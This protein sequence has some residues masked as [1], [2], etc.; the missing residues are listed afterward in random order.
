MSCGFD[1]VVLD[2][3]VLQKELEGLGKNQSH[4]ES[5]TGNLSFHASCDQNESSNAE[6]QNFPQII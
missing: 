2:G 1:S 5:L 6:R 4:Q 3:Q